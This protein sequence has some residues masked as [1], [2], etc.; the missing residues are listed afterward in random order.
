MLISDTV[1]RT[2]WCPMV[3]IDNNNRLHKV[4]ELGQDVSL[5]RQ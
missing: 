2:K 4:R 3:R 5:H 1:A